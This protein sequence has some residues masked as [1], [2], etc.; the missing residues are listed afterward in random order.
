MSTKLHVLVVEDESFTRQL[1]V[2]ALSQQGFEVSDTDNASSAIQLVRQVEPNVVL[3]DLDLGSGANGL[4]LINLISR[5]YPWIGLVVLTAHSDPVLVGVGSVPEGATY[6]VKSA[7]EDLN[8]IGQ[9]VYRSISNV[10][11]E[12]KG[13]RTTDNNEPARPR[14]VS[15]SQA[16]MLRLLSNGLTNQ[17]IAQQRGTTIRAVETMIQRT[18]KALGLT[19][20][21]SRNLRVEAVS[22]WRQGKVQVK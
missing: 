22:L 12:L 13:Q 21:G 14:F 6:L 5:E 2:S 19:Q 8:Q 1:I 7:I 18:Y 11:F 3:S 15:N 9:A 20:N 17:A 16:E 10:A 4:D